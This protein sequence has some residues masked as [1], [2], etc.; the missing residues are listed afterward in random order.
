M[1]GLMGSGTPE[2]H[3][4]LHALDYTGKRVENSSDQ[5]FHLPGNFLAKG[6]IGLWQ[7]LWQEKCQEILFGRKLTGN[8]INC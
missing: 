8:T 4:F 7:N 3:A 2:F 5:S 1:I 6:N